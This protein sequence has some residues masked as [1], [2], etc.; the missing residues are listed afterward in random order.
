MLDSKPRPPTASGHSRRVRYPDKE[1]HDGALLTFPTPPVSTGSS[2]S[3]P[4]GFLGALAHSA[5]SSLTGSEVG[6]G[7]LPGES[8]LHPAVTTSDRS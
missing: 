6:S 7:A 3:S 5:P 8:N 4:V 2:Y 1:C